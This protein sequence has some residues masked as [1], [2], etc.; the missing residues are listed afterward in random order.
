M[1]LGEVIDTALLFIVYMLTSLILYFSIKK[2]S[3]LMS[4]FLS[5]AYLTFGILNL[6][7]EDE[8]IFSLISILWALVC[9][10]VSFE[11]NNLIKEK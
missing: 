1:F 10:I 2:R 7:Y 8:A 9:F 4:S 5:G 3:I 6:I 11:I